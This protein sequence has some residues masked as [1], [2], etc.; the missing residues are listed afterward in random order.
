MPLPCHRKSVFGLRCSPHRP[1]L[2]TVLSALAD[3]PSTP[4]VGPSTVVGGGATVVVHPSATVVDPSTV[5][6][7]PPTAIVDPAIPPVDPSTAIFAPLTPS[8]DPSRTA[9][10]PSTVVVD[11]SENCFLTR[12]APRDSGSKPARAEYPA[13]PT[14][15]DTRIGKIEFYESRM[16]PWAAAGGAIGLSI[17]SITAQTSR[18]AA[19]RAA[20]D[21]HLAAEAA[22]RAATAAFTEAVR[23]MHGDAGAGSDMI[24]I[25]R[26]HAQVTDDPEVYSL[27]QI[28]PPKTPGTLPPPGTPSSFRVDLLADGA[29]TLSW[30]CPHP[31]GAEGTMYEVLRSVDGGDFAFLTTVG[32]R[33]FTDRSVPAGAAEVVYEVTAVRSTTR[34]RPARRTVRFGVGAAASNADVGVAA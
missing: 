11:G 33:A 30:K 15:P 29:L 25:I 18:V 10:D 23:A 26:N 16:A 24:A 28:P 19:A 3:E 1:L 9:V 7:D 6:V 22:A 2:L 32:T 21:A 5:P 27:A 13:M 20:Y 12:P 34:G 14:V 17:D 8:F 4:P 31:R